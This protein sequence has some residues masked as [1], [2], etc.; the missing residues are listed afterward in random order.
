[1]PQDSNIRSRFAPIWRAV[2]CCPMLTQP[3]NLPKHPQIQL[4]PGNLWVNSGL[5]AGSVLGKVKRAVVAGTVRKVGIAERFP[6][7]IPRR[8]FHS[9]C[10]DSVLGL[11]EKAMKSATG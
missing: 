4:G 1:M 8:L 2:P 6:R 3:P 7:R 10:W 5:S 9:P 11:T